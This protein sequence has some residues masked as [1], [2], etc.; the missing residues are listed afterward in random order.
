VL[1]GLLDEPHSP[2]WDEKATPTVETR[3]DVIHQALTAADAELTASQGNDPQSWRW[4]TMH[5]LYVRN[6][7]FGSSGI[8]PIEWLFNHGPEGVSGG[9]NIVN[10]TGWDAS[11][12]YEVDAVP[13][14]RM[15]VDLSNLDASRWVQLTGESGH[16]FSP[17]YTDQFELWRTG[18]T[19]PMRWD[20][21]SVR[22][23]TVDT[24]TLK[25]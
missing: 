22:A 9:S 11:V 19:L 15:I 13:S 25:P 21:A 12:G 5:T 1:T 3:D 23:S 7:S 16:A 17:H 8:G 18:Q 6:Q 2:W 4:G 20:E 24:L 10:A 14:M